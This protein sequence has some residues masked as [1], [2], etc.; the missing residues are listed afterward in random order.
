MKYISHDDYMVTINQIIML[1]EGKTGKIVRELEAEMKAKS[2]NQEYEEAA[3]IRDRI[4]SIERMSEKQK[5]S[6]ISENNID[7][8]GIYKNELSVC[9]EIF[10]VRGSRMIDREHYFFDDLKEMEISEILSGFIKQYYIG[11]L[12]YPNKIM[13]QEEIEDKEI[14]EEYLSK[15]AGR[16][17]CSFSR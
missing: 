13:I 17:T 3:R 1:L 11:K 2:I 6:N 10:F 4:Q 9:V 7:V 8:V 16:K 14:I 5:V 15:A 12:E